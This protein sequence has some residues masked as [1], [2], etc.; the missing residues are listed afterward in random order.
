MCEKCPNRKYLENFHAVYIIT[1]T[2]SST[3]IWNSEVTEQKVQDSMIFEVA[4]LRDSE[5]T[6][7]KNSS[8]ILR[9]R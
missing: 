4:R 1:N 3:A 8:E 6:P 5:I 7:G 2:Q 9:I